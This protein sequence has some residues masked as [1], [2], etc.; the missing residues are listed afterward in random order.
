MRTT[1]DDLSGQRFGHLT[2]VRFLGLR[3]VRPN[4]QSRRRT[5]EC[6]CDCGNLVE[7]SA[8]DLI[9]LEGSSQSCGCGVGNR[10]HSMTD[11][12][13]YQAWKSAKQRCENR[14]NPQYKNY[15]E[16]GITMC[17]E[18]SESFH[19]F[20]S[21]MGTRPKPDLT[22]ERIDNSR[23]YEPGNVRWATWVDQANNRRPRRNA[24]GVSFDGRSQSLKAWC[25]E[26]GINYEAARGRRRRGW[27]IERI[28]GKEVQR[29]KSRAL[30]E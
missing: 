30:Q 16:R 19:A 2:A 6:K 8:T 17:D 20:M 13:E 24:N 10:V 15:G 21:H 26:L 29:P 22:L 9:Y 14:N 23:G 18:W 1:R 25:A 3:H 12:P 5:W 7:R 27:P 4:E 11:S 28:F